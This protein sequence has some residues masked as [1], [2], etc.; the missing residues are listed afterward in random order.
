MS[1]LLSLVSS[2]ASDFNLVLATLASI[3]PV[4]VAI[5]SPVATICVE[6][7]EALLAGS[8]WVHFLQM[9]AVAQDA[10]EYEMRNSSA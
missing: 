2:H 10:I 8:P 9:E 6:T 4:N 1:T 3:H 7:Q 5:S